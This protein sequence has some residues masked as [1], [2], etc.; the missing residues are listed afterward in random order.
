[1]KLAPPVVSR[2][3]ALKG[4]EGRLSL[5]LFPLFIAIAALGAILLWV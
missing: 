4:F 1:M 3:G 2:R 5:I